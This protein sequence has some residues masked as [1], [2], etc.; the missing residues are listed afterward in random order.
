MLFRAKKVA[1]G[2]VTKFIGRNKQDGDQNSYEPGV[3]WSML[4]VQE[5]FLKAFISS[6]IIGATL[7]SSTRKH[8]CK[9]VL[10][11]PCGVFHKG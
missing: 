4:F 11:C 6:L 1:Q 9:N 5:M 2:M 10:H 7:Q 3:Y 8:E